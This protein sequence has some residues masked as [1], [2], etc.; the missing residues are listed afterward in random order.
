MFCVFGLWVIVSCV[1]S[2]E[3]RVV[4]IG[5][6]LDLCP[7][8]GTHVQNI[9]EIGGIEFLNKKSKGKGTQRFSYTLKEL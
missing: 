2:S 5:D 7:C 4:I 8:A 9:S 3:L 1:V 6:N